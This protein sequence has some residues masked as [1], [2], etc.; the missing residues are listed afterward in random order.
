MFG[1]GESTY[2]VPPTTMGADSWP[3]VHAGRERERDLQIL[4]VVG[5]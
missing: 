2:I 1:Y 4:D 3:A 5:R